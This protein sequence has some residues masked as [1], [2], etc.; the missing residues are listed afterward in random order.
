MELLK[1]K[2]K[3]LNLK[4]KKLLLP[5]LGII[6]ILLIGFSSVNDKQQATP[7][8]SIK[9]TDAEYC[10]EL[11][12]KIKSLVSAITGDTDCIV[13]VTLESSGEYI[14]ANQNTVD[15]DQSEDTGGGSTTTRQTHK[16]EQQYIIVEGENGEQSALVVTEKKPNVRGVAIVTAGLNDINFEEVLSSVS[17]MLGVASRK[18]NISQKAE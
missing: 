3:G 11:E 5:V 2:L 8:I 13:A 10:N 14:Y 7:S 12:L 18:I 9:Q 15:T 6:G 16:S 1:E 17:S 4:N